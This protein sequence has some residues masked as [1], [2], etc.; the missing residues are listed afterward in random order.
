MLS[1]PPRQLTGGRY[2]VELLCVEVLVYV[3]FPELI[4]ALPFRLQKQSTLPSG[5]L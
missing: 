4:N 2:Q 1:T 3:G 5:A